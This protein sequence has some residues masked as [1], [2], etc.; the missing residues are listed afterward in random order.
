M[1][2]NFTKL[3]CIGIACFYMVSALAQENMPVVSTVKGMDFTENHVNLRADETESWWPDSVIYYNLSTGV[4]RAKVCYDQENRTTTHAQF[5]NGNW[6]FDE[7]YSSNGY[8]R[9]GDYNLS[10]RESNGGI[11]VGYRTIWYVPN[12]TYGNC[13]SNAVYDAKGNLTSLEIIPNAN[14]VPVAAITYRIKYNDK[15]APVLL[16]RY[17]YDDLQDYTQFEYNENGHM[18]LS[19][20]YERANS[21]MEISRKETLEFDE[22]GRPAEG[23]AIWSNAIQ[24]EHIIFYYSDGTSSNEQIKSAASIAYLIDQ[25]L[26]IQSEKADRITVYSIMGQTLYETAIQPG[27]NTI[28]VSQLPQGILIVKAS[29]GW[30]MKVASR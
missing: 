23:H 6:I 21:R 28:N 9:P 22:K 1:R 14:P 2:K 20:S 4:P 19:E 26:Y 18:I 16:E 30:V 11:Y 15:N 12:V 29:S 24:S 7:P 17:A 13:Y 25:T 10:F 5:D 8:S 27:M 3:V